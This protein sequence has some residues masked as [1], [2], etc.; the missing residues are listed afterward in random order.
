MK[1]FSECYY[2]NLTSI[3]ILNYDYKQN[4][5]KYDYKQSSS[6]IAE[7]TRLLIMFSL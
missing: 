4:K 1:I 6:K 2:I 7:K 3:V 5:Q